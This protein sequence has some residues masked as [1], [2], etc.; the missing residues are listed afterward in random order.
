M[1]HKLLALLTLL[2]VLGAPLAVQAQVGSKPVVVVSISS[3][4]ELLDDIKHVMSLSDNEATFKRSEATINAFSNGIDKNRPWGAAVSFTDS[5]PNAVSFVPVTNFDAALGSL[6][7]LGVP[8][9]VGG[10]VKKIGPVFIM[11]QDGYAYI[12]QSKAGLQR[13]PDPKRTLGALPGQYDMAVSVSLQNLDRN[14]KAQITGIM[15]AQVQTTLNNQPDLTDAQRKMIEQ[16]L[17]SL[18]QLLNEG[19]KITIG[20]NVDRKAKSIYFDVAMTAIPG[21]KAAQQIAAMKDAETKFGEVVRPGAP[22]TANLTEQ[23][24][25]EDAEQA[26][27]SFQAMTAAL[28]DAI[29]KSEEFDSDDQRDMVKDWVRRG[30][31]VAQATAS[32]GLWDAAASVAAT[33]NG[34]L[35]LLAGLHVVRG[36]DLDALAQEILKFGQQAA[37]DEFPPLKLNAETY[38]GANIHTITLPMPPDAKAAERVTKL[39]GDKPMLHLAF[40]NDTV[41]VAA[42][43]GAIDTLKGAMD[44]TQQ[45]KKVPPLQ[46]S[47]ALADF[48]RLV[49]E[50]DDKNPALMPLANALQPGSDMIRLSLSPIENGYKMRFEIN[51][52]V[53]KLIGVASTLSGAGSAP[54]FDLE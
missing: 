37:G 41:W 44:G 40:S 14:L 7:L 19:D 46:V 45:R 42:G 49:A 32:K 51:D 6:A 18:T 3:L 29:D 23:V 31:D 10:G 22:F 1:K 26:V 24:S 38:K 50:A 5:V 20:L 30:M 25:P 16:R 8:E 54:G 9:D 17:E 15:A 36:K 52:G 39:F 35:N 12:A 28:L 48:M 4:Q 13:V 47:V 2:L 53:V 27:A 11:E 33:S 34:P 21:T 43:T